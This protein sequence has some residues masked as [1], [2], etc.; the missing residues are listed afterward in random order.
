MNANSNGGAA[1]SA[2]AA[3]GGAV[4]GAAGAGAGAGGASGG[5]GPG[6]GPGGGGGGGGAGDAGAGT[7]NSAT[8]GATGL[9]DDQDAKR[10]KCLETDEAQDG[11]STVSMH[12]SSIP[13]PTS[14]IH[15]SVFFFH[16]N[17]YLYV[18]TADDRCKQRAQ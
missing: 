16:L 1:A 18:R 13:S 8:N 9:N 15:M 11:A 17:K 3:G 7:S 12:I 2:G 14:Y 10:R 6:P 5:G 4:G